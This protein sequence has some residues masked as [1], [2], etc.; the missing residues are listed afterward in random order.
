MIPDG[1]GTPGLPRRW[2]WEEAFRSGL[3]SRFRRERLQVF[4]GSVSAGIEQLA[5]TGLLFVNGF[6]LFYVGLLLATSL[7][8]VWASMGP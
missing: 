8:A 4:I 3:R 5:V 2:R 7:A 6:G 1:R